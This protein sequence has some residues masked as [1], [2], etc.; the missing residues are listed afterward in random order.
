MGEHKAQR[1]ERD[2]KDAIM[3]QH[4]EDSDKTIAAV[5]G[6]YC[7]ACTLF[8]ATKEDP[9][10]LKKIAAHYRLPEE[11]V[12]CYGCRSTVR[13]P[14]CRTC[15][16]SSCAAERGI[17]FCVECADCPCDTLRQFQSEMPH[18]I[19]LWRDLE[20]I[21]TVGYEP[22]LEKVR[23][24]YACP[25]CGTINSTYDSKCRACGEEP[26]CRYVA[27]HRQEIEQYFKNR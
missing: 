26:S 3:T 21:R 14:Y 12:R 27:A 23:D 19:E 13:G 5:C 24:R 8:I 20:Q 9:A 6:L 18:R 22:W 17:D 2:V 16:M 1:I 4:A 7:E 25:R 10:R 15:V 11:E